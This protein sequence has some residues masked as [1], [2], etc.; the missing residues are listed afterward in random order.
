MIFSD[1]IVI[2]HGP[3]SQDVVSM[4]SEALDELESKCRTCLAVKKLER[5]MV[6]G[7]FLGEPLTDDDHDYFCRTVYKRAYWCGAGINIELRKEAT[8]RHTKRIKYDELLQELKM[9]PIHMQ[10]QMNQYDDIEAFFE[11]F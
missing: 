1:A 9:H 7:L 11:S 3:P 4:L 6:H 5:F 10:H 8:A 2:E